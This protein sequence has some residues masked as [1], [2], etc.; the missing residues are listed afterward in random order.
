MNGNEESFLIAPCGLSCA[1]CPAYLVKDN[2]QLKEQ[3]IAMLSKSNPAMAENLTKLGID[4]VHCE[5]CRLKNSRRKNSPDIANLSDLPDSVA[6]IE[7][8][9]TYA[10]SIERGVDF[11]YECS[12]FPCVKLQPCADKADFA[13]H[14]LKVFNLCSLQRQGPA[15]WLKNYAETMNLFRFGILVIGEGPGMTEEALMRAREQ[16]DRFTA[17]TRPGEKN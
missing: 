15:E 17:K 12:D 5:G 14:N 3:L 4:D 1:H 10:C 8:C 11:C 2:P 6:D 13:P 9:A 7:P 16:H